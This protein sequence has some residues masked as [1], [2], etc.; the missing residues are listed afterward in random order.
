MPFAMEKVL[1]SFGLLFLFTLFLSTHA[2]LTIDAA[3]AAA[4]P[5]RFLVRRSLAQQSKAR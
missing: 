1:L 3:A 4:Y 2:G 5:E